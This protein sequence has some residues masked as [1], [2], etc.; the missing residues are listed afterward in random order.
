MVEGRRDGEDGQVVRPPAA[1][2]LENISRL[3]IGRAAHLPQLTQPIWQSL[4]SDLVQG[5]GRKSNR[6]RR[7]CP[8]QKK[9]S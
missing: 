1:E 8:Q 2:E 3:D 4:W 5:W 6:E 9:K 7:D